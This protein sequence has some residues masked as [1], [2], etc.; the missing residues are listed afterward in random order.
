MPE[1]LWQTRSRFSTQREREGGIDAV[2]R[3]IANALRKPM[4]TWL[5]RLSLAIYLSGHD[6]SAMMNAV[7][8]IT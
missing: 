5:R 6:G 3:T 4:W 7:P 8:S 1:S 2:E